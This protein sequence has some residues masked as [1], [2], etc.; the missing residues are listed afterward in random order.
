MDFNKIC[1][2]FAQNFYE[3]M[4]KRTLQDKLTQYVGKGKAILLIGARQVGK[5]TLFKMLTNEISEENLIWLNC[6]QENVRD[7]LSNSSIVNLQLLIADK[8]F[9]VIDEAQRVPN[10]GLTLKLIVDNFPN[11]QLFVTGS[12]AL[13]LHNRLNEPLTGRKIEYKLYPISTEEIYKAKGLVAVNEFFERRLIYGSYPDVLLGNLP[14]EKV[15]ME[16]TE[17]YLYKDI[18]EIEGIR[19]SSVLQKLLV[20]LALQ[21]G[22]EVSY[23][24]LSKIVGIDNKTIEKYIDILEKCYIVFR[25]NCFSRNLRTELTK[26]K[27][28]YFYDLGVRNA[29]LQAF[30]P[31]N[32]RQDTGALWENFFIAERMKYNHYADRLVNA[33]FWR[34]KNQQEIDYIEEV[35]GEL[36]LFEMKWNVKKQNTA[37]SNLFVETYNPKQINIVTP[38]NYLSFLIS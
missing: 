6:D 29:I 22:S 34:T 18:L 21:I 16:L 37:I 10:I 1:C 19:K 31:L 32:V 26:S 11:V 27:K 5:S 2:I 23:N 20:A 3:T 12:S 33:Y 13:D 4:I 24:E 38:E 36:H 30:M 35:S 25:L 8:S 9:V 15:L 14:A 7:T 28:I 17:S